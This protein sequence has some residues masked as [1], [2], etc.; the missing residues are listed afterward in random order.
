M[1]IS[2]TSCQRAGA[3]E[4]GAKPRHRDQRDPTFHQHVQR[5]GGWYWWECYP[6]AFRMGKRSDRSRPAIAP[7]VMRLRAAW[8]R[9]DF[10]VEPSA[11]QPAVSTFSLA[12][13]LWRAA[14]C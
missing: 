7:T 3:D 11:N 14:R 5:F 9:G 13:R 12:L 10:G 1:W 8:D 4:G 6:G 2:A